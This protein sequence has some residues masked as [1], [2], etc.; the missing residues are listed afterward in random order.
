MGYCQGGSEWTRLSV[1]IQ[2]CRSERVQHASW[3]R[4]KGRLELAIYKKWMELRLGEFIFSLLSIH[5]HVFRYP[6]HCFGIACST[7][8]AGT[9]YSVHPTQFNTALYHVVLPQFA[10]HFILVHSASAATILPCCCITSRQYT[11]LSFQQF[12][13]QKCLATTHTPAPS[14]HFRLSRSSP[15]QCQ[16]IQIFHSVPALSLLSLQLLLQQWSWRAS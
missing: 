15:L 9:L 3:R 8:L 14:F 1:T 13:I 7:F 6:S 2:V 4:T 10:T 11:P 16:L 5:F 12:Q